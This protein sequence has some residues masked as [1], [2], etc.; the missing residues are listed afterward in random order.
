MATTLHITNGDAAARS[1]AQ[2]G[3]E[4]PVLPWRDVLHEGPVPA[5][6]ELP[7]LS[8][9]RARFIARRRWGE[10]DDVE[11]DF[12]RRDATLAAYREHD[13]VVLWFEHDLY[14]QLQLIQLLDWFAD[15]PPDTTRL[16][17]VQSDDYLS[18]LDE[19]ALRARF[20]ARAGVR[21]EQLDL[22]RAA[23]RAFRAPDPAAIL[24]VLAD[25]TTSLPYLAPAL[26]RHLEQ[27]PSTRE[28][29]SR[30]ERQALGVISS[31][32]AELRQ[33]FAG[34]AESEEAIFLGDRVFMDYLE[35]MSR[36]TTPLV[37]WEDRSAIIAPDSE[38][39]MRAL[40][41]R[42]AAVTDA[43]ERVLA[44]AADA[45]QLNGIDRW[46][47][48]THLVTGQLWRWDGDRRALHAEHR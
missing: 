3:I 48:G 10:L 26:L 11:R 5:G 37:L 41:S 15:H 16:E 35:R 22:A 21:R 31:G 43:G 19:T 14:D 23:W 29:L 24:D 18:S 38:G 25:D 8:R 12:A 6:L 27:F 17:L 47:G 34:C 30:S 1:I 40:W 2:A 32:R 44:A 36:A 39:E 46:L 42:R 13:A 7:E 9:E 4:G 28:G 20:D 45:V 33:A